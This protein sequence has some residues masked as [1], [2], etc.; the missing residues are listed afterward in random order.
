MLITTCKKSVQLAGSSWFGS[1][2]SYSSL[3]PSVSGTSGKLMNKRQSV[4]EVVNGVIVDL[5][6]SASRTRETSG[7]RC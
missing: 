4:V 2:K 6:V 5:S 3:G 1:T 7:S